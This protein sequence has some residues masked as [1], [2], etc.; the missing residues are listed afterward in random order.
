MKPQLVWTLLLSIVAVGCASR[1]QQAKT[2]SGASD[3]S[4]LKLAMDVETQIQVGH[5]FV[6]ESKEEID[7]A[8]RVDFSPNLVTKVY[9]LVNG[10]ITKIN[11]NQGNVVKKGDVLA[12]IYS[13]D[14]ASAVSDFQ[15]ANAQLKTA[16]KNYARA[17][18]LAEAKIFSQRELQQAATDSTQA[19]A[20]YDRASKVL[21]L[22]NASKDSG[23][24][25]FKVNAPIDGIVLERFAQIGSQVR[26]DNSQNLFTIGLIKSVWVIL[27]VY[28]DQLP[29]IS[30]SDRALLT[31]DGLEDT[32]I[33]SSIRYVSP[34]IDPTTM[35]AKARCEVDNRNG[36]IKPAM[37]CSAKVYHRK[38]EA[39]FLPSSAAFYDGDGKT[40][41]FAKIDSRKYQKREVVVGKALAD[42][43][44]ILRGVSLKDEIVL[45]QAI[46]L[47]EE[48]QLASK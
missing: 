25:V 2:D 41:V 8:G 17:K 34:I 27:D 28:Q 18:E 31:F 13:G 11:V 14:F 21:T 24:A 43:I 44:E 47:N 37:F 20:E 7:L 9:S 22:L 40:Y 1:Q 6:Q 45:N 36:T 30:T 19:R 16:E 48:L 26:N 4:I 29:K 38:G 33:V 23:S 42:K 32:T 15:K 46:F 3:S 12:E 35:T 39:L 10:T 5:P